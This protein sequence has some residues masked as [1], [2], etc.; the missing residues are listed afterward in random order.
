[1]VE[2]FPPVP[3]T[4]SRNGGR[5]SPQQLAVW[6]AGIRSHAP[7]VQG[8]ACFH[9]AEFVGVALREL[10]RSDVSRRC[11]HPP[12]RRRRPDVSESLSGGQTR[13]DWMQKRCQIRF[14]D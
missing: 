11:K 12:Y 1:M 4:L 14:C 6:D 2:G 10:R 8:A 13:L 5:I 7:G 9:A 3:A